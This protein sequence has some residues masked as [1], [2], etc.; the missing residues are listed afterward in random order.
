MDLQKTYNCSPLLEFNSDKHDLIKW[1]WKTDP[2]QAVYWKTYKP[3]KR[4]LR[5]I[6]KISR[7]E[8]KLITN[9]LYAEIMQNDFPKP[10]KKQ[11]VRRL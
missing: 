8:R 2:P 6:S 1:T 10:I 5:V 7:E 9:E 3:K 4:D 11:K